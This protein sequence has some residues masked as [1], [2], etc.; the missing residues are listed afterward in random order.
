MNAAKIV[1]LSSTAKKQN[2]TN[3]FSETQILTMTKERISKMI[4]L[5]LRIPNITCSFFCKHQM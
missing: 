3:T 5:L 4:K 1:M 2:N